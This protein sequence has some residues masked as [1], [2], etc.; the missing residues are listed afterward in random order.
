MTS[1]DHNKYIGFCFLA[2]AGFQFL[3]LFLMAAWFYFVFRGFPAPPGDPGP[4]IEFFGF[5]FAFMAI[6]QLIFTAPAAIASYAVFKRKPWA[7]M[8]SI[9]ASVFASMSMPIGT[10]ACV[11]A[12]WFF[13][14]DRWKE[15]YEPPVSS[16][17]FAPI[18]L[19]EAASWDPADDQRIRDHQYQPKPGD[20]R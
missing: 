1:E 20:W 16:K 6:F 8:A 18:E 9:V 10:G 5:I 3:M 14:G 4:P 13:L 15:V 7:R 12:L 17:Q 11:Y 2:Y 19:S